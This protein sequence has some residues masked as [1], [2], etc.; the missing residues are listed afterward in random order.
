MLIEIVIALL[1]GVAIGVITGILPGIHINLIGSLLLSSTLSIIFNINPIYLV[2][3]IVSMS[4]THIFIDFIPSIYLGAP[5]DS[6]ILSVLPGHKMLLQGKAHEAVTITLF[7]CLISIIVVI[8]L[9]PILIF[10]LP[11]LNEI[12]TPFISFILIILSTI[13]IFKEKYKI[14]ALIIFLLAGFLGLATLNL[15]IKEPLLPLLT[16]L[17]GS[18]SLILTIKQKTQIPKQKITTIKQIKLKNNLPNLLISTLLSCLIGFLPSIGASQIATFS[19]IIKK[20]SS[21]QFLFSLGLISSLTMV[22]SFITVFTINKSRT[23]SAV[24]IQQLLNEISLNQIIFILII[25]LLTG[26]LSFILGI[27]ISK[28]F[29]NNIQKF[30]YTKISI[31]VLVFLTA[32]VFLI[33]GILG[34]I[35]FTTSTFLGIFCNLSEVRRT[36]LM[37][38]LILPTIILYLF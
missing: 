8:F 37:A 9:A 6:S 18:S 23:G 11:E 10:S 38:S 7:G 2:V 31:F 20:Q 30:N 27:K 28:F 5:D 16:G 25:S 29:A 33:S 15:P 22:L 32:I 12:V 17:F 35:V 4:I 34:L 1:I 21:K 36:N 14:S 26:I 19:S 13:L 24:F 3:F